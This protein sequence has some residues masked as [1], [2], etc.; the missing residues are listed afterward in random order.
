MEIFGKFP[1]FAITS[2]SDQIAQN[3]HVTAMRRSR[4]PDL[5]ELTQRMRDNRAN[6]VRSFLKDLPL[7]TPAVSQF[8]RITRHIFTH[9][10]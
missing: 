4:E 10:S 7:V 5:G 2:P 3:R 6:K 9:E 1:A 8:I